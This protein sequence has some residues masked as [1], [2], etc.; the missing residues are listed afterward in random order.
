[1]RLSEDHR[2]VNSLKQILDDYN[3]LEYDDKR[4]KRD[5]DFNGLHIIVTNLQSVMS[6]LFRIFGVD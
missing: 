3:Y 2:I 1:M 5:N 4:P 6:K